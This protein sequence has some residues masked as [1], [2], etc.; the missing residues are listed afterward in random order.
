ME[1]F[2]KMQDRYA[3]DIGDFGKFSLLRYLFRNKQYKLG[4]IWY[5]YRNESHNDDGKHIDYFDKS[6]FNACDIKLIR[7]LQKIVKTKRSIR[8]LEKAKLLPDNTVYYSAP[9]SFYTDHPGQTATA[10]QARK[11]ARDNWLKD[12][13]EKVSICNVIFLDPDNG[14]EIKSVPG[15]TQKTSGKYAY[16]SEVDKLSKGKKVCVI[17]H[18]LSRNNSH[19]NQIKQRVQQLSNRMNKGDVVFALRYSPYSPRAYF[20][21]TIQSEVKL[22]RKRLKEFMSGSCAYGWDSYYEV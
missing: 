8:S 16:Y 10:K 18:H 7:E 6:E 2:K 15:M 1:L 5:R 12:A 4:V 21:L 22:M 3:G 11:N 9:L 20:I 13:I 17:Y 19:Q 14:L